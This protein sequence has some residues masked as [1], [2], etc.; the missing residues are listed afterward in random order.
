MKH[1]PDDR[2]TRYVGDHADKLSRVRAMPH[3]EDE[4]PS[5]EDLARGGGGGVFGSMLSVGRQMLPK[6]LRRK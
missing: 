2:P 4:R 5:R 1:S 6:P 3:D